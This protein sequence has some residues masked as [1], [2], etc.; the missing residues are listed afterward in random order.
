MYNWS[1][2]YTPPHPE[3]RIFKEVPS[4]VATIGVLV[5]MNAGVWFL[6]RLPPFWNLLNTYTTSVPAVPYT[7][8]LLGN[9]FS[10]SSFKH[11]MSNMIGLVLWGF[12][13]T[14]FQTSFRTVVHWAL[15]PL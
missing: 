1:E 6:W 9:T 11:L 15:L 2:H 4:S 8:S 14:Y 13:G 10:H 12:P 3:L 5:A 7:F